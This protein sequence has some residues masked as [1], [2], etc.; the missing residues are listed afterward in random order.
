MRPEVLGTSQFYDL[1]DETLV[2][3]LN[4]I[5]GGFSNRLLLQEKTF[6]IRYEETLAFLRFFSRKFFVRN[7]IFSSCHKIKSIRSLAGSIGRRLARTVDPRVICTM[8]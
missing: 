2:T 4:I 6:K 8:I 7:C 1:I 5:T 3:S